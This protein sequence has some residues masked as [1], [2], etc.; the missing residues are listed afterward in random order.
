MVKKPLAKRLFGFSFKRMGKLLLGM[1]V[2]LLLLYWWYPLQI[3]LVQRR[4]AHPLPVIP[5]EQIG[6]VAKGNRVLVITAHPDDEGYY[7]CGTLTMLKHAG[8][9]VQIVVCTNGDK[10][11]WPFVNSAAIAKNRQKEMREACRRYGTLEPIFLGFRDGR[12]HADQE[13]IGK[14]VDQI[15]AFKPGYIICFD[16]DYPPRM[17]HSDHRASGYAAAKAAEE[18]QFSGWLMRFNTFGPNTAIDVGKY[19]DEAVLGIEAHASQYGERLEMVKFSAGNNT[20]DVGE[21]FGMSQGEQFRA[22]KMGP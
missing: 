9:K 5:P 6:L 17:S 1:A 10:G 20:Y 14:L 11:F 18:A 2:V 16:S 22:V 12:L 4:P 8:A 3:D 13:V 19:W 15:K 7:L 21:R